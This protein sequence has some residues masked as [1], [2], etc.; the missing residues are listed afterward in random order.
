MRDESHQ[1]R[2][3]Y[4]HFTRTVLVTATVFAVG[5]VFADTTL[6]TEQSKLLKAPDAISR[7]DKHLFGDKI[8]LYNGH[9]EFIQTDVDLRGNNKLPVMVGRRFD[10]TA[11]N[12]GDAMFR[13]WDLEIPYIHGVFSQKYGWQK[14]DAAGQISPMRCTNFGAPPTVSG[15]YDAYKGIDYWYGN[16]MYVPGVG[17]QAILKRDP[18]NANIPA[19]GQ[20]TPLVTKKDWAVRCLPSLA[21][22]TATTPATLRAPKTGIFPCRASKFAFIRPW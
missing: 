3:S 5:S 2:S 12:I 9:L 18:S 4:H 19:D 14:A 13:H 17:D 1:Y 8:N 16:S 7:L 11:E 22:R 20:A 15:A 6:Q 21:S 10:T